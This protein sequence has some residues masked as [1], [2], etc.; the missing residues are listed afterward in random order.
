MI[1]KQKLTVFILSSLILSVSL[2]S[3]YLLDT[4]DASIDGSWNL[5]FYR[6]YDIDGN[7]YE[8]SSDGA[9]SSEVAFYVEDSSNG[10]MVGTIDGIA[11]TGS[12]ANGLMT[13]CP[14]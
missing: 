5:A 3:F 9:H 10:M 7:Y 4:S 1:K 11:F 8:W 12:I 13:I 6:G 14:V 2:F